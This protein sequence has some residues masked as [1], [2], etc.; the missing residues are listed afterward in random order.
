V[1]LCRGGRS[2]S[3]CRARWP[4]WLGL[5]AGGWRIAHRA[6]HA[7][8]QHDALE[9]A[10]KATTQYSTLVTALEARLR[11]LED[12]TNALRAENARLRQDLEAAHATARSAL[13][14]AEELRAQLTICASARR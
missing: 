4:R 6:R 8:N 7:L 9:L 2:G 11:A 13:N 5:V 3:T 14:A 10:Q 1:T 12:E